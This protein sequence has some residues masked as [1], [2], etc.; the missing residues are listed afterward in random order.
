MFCHESLTFMCDHQLDGLS[1]CTRLSGPLRGGKETATSSGGVS[2][3]SPI[4]MVL[5]FLILTM[6]VAIGLELLPHACLTA[7]AHSRPMAVA[8]SPAIAR[9]GRH[10]RIS[11]SGRNDALELRVPGLVYCLGSST[12]PFCQAQATIAARECFPVFS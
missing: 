11:G 3:Q 8:C 12:N 6:M 7:V 4:Y 2:P 1:G 9:S 10:V 5:L